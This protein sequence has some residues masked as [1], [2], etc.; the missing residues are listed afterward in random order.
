MSGRASHAS[1]LVNNKVWIIGGTFFSGSTHNFVAVY[2]TVNASWE[3]IRTENGPSI[4]YDH[5]LVRYKVKKSFYLTW[6][7][8]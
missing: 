6:C 4:R 3:E 8:C 1:V 7:W 5:S 2:N